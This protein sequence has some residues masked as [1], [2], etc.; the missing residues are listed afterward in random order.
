MSKITSQLSGLIFFV[1][2]TGL[3]TQLLFSAGEVDAWRLHV[4]YVYPQ[5]IGR[6]LAIFFYVRI[7]TPPETKKK[8]VVPDV[9]T[10][11]GGSTFGSTVDSTA[12]TP[13]SII[14]SSATQGSTIASTLPM[15]NQKTTP[16]TL[17]TATTVTTKV[18][19][20]PSSAW[21]SATSSSGS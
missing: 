3:A 17:T 18:S 2:F 7:V 15:S 11:A 9:C 1:F 14:A 21:D 5:V 6:N 8:K 10:D 20:G 16:D 4:V 12:A 19:G 13:K